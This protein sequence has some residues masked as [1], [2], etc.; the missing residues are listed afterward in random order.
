[1]KVLVTGAAGKLGSAVCAS[2]L[3]HGHEVTATDHKHRDGLKSKL[4]LA[5]LRDDIA[6]YALLEG[7]DA[8]AHLGNHANLM[9]GPSPQRLIAENTAMNANPKNITAYLDAREINL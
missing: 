2:L 8:V 5:D 6:V 7:C 1:M 9:A 4:V 3:E